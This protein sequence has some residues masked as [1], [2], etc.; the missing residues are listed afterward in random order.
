M[1]LYPVRAYTWFSQNK[2]YSNVMNKD[3]KLQREAI[4]DAIKE[5]AIIC[6]SCG[7]KIKNFNQCFVSHAFAY[8][9]T[10]TNYCNEKCYRSNKRRIK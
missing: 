6:N 7:N 9:F 4:K 8:G 5:G 2:E 10:D 1:S 3:L